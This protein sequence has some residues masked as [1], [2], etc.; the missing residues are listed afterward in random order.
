LWIYKFKSVVWN[1]FLYKRW[2]KS[3]LIYMFFHTETFI[4]T[5]LQ[6]LLLLYLHFLIN[7][8]PHFN[9]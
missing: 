7:F 9:T 6:S 3:H 4:D 1:H 8:F 5:S 2:V